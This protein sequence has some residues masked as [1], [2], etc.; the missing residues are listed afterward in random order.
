MARGTKT[1]EFLKECMADAL[2]KLITEKDIGKISVSEITT[3][4][5]VGRATWFRNFESKSDAVT[6]KLV[7]L[8]KRWAS[9]HNI[10]ESCQLNFKNAKDFF[11]FNYDIRTLIDTIYAVGMQNC[12]YDAFCF[13]MESQY[14]T[15]VF[16]SYQIRF[17]AY[18][19]FGLLEEWKKRNFKE[20]PDEMVDLFFKIIDDHSDM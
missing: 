1:T 14:G 7:Q 17:Y 6:Y 13:V 12:I 20:S 18:G 8:W 11:L 10:S 16:K 19:V 9:E 3:L 15:S 4:A 5:G 2:I